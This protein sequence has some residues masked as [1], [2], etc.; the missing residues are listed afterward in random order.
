MIQAT[1]KSLDYVWDWVDE[2]FFLS[3]YLKPVADQMGLNTTN[4]N[5]MWKDRAQMELTFA[6]LNSFTVSFNIIIRPKN[7]HRASKERIQAEKNITRLSKAP[8]TLS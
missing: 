8:F 1:I 7:V 3:L 5:S 4:N 6:T 2:L